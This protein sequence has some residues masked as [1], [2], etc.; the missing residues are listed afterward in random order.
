MARSAFK[1]KGFG[2]FGNSPAKQVDLT[3]KKGKG[4]RAEVKK[5]DWE[6]M[7]YEEQEAYMNEKHHGIVP[8]I[9][10]FIEDAQ[11]KKKK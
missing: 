8:R 9:H 10:D 1:M 2:G 7:S 6:K 5:T 3:K 11:N 4:P